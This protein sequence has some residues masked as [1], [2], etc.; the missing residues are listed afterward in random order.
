MK[1]KY[2]KPKSGNRLKYSRAKSTGDAH[3][4]FLVSQ[5]PQLLVL[6]F[7]NC[8]FFFFLKLSSGTLAACRRND[9]MIRATGRRYT[10]GFYIV[11]HPWLLNN[12]VVKVGYSTNV[13]Q[14]FETASYKT[15]FTPEWCF[16]RVLECESE[17]DAL[18]L[19]QAVLHCLGPYRVYRRELLRASAEKVGKAA[20]EIAQRLHINVIIHTNF[21]SNFS[22][23]KKK[24]DR[25]SGIHDEEEA[26]LEDSATELFDSDKGISSKSSEKDKEIPLKKTRTKYLD[27]PSPSQE[28]HDP[29]AQAITPFL[30]ILNSLSFDK[31]PEINRSTSVMQDSSSN[32]ALPD[33]EE[34]DLCGSWGEASLPYDFIDEKSYHLGDLRPY[35]KE[36]VQRLR[37]ELLRNGKAICQMACRCGKTPVAFQLI[38]EYFSLNYKS[39]SFV[40][41]K[42][43]GKK[44]II[45][46]LVPGLSLLRQT[47][48]KLFQYGLGQ[49]KVRFVLIG[50]HPDPVFLSPSSVTPMTTDVQY[51]KD[52]TLRD[53]NILVISTYHSSSLLKEV[54]ARSSLVVFDECHRICGSSEATLFNALLQTPSCGARLFMTATPTYDTPIKMNN[55][56]YFGSI[57]FRYYLREG[58]NSGY[59]NPFGVRIILGHSLDNMN[60]FLLEAMSHVDKLLVFCR[61]IDHAE[62]LFKRA[63]EEVGKSESSSGEVLPF[64]CFVAHSRMSCNSVSSA[65]QQFMSCKRGILFNVRLFQEGVEIPDLNGVFFACPRYSSRDIIQSICRPLSKVEG[66]PMSFVFLPAVLDSKSPDSSPINLENFSTLVP[67]ADALMDEDP[68]L[69]EY[70]IDPENKTYN[71]SVVGVRSLPLMSER[72]QQFILPS[73]RRG[74]RFSSRNSD[75]LRRVNRFPWKNVFAEL[76]RVVEECNRYPKTNDA[77]VVG[78]TSFS[79]NSFYQ[80][81]RKGYH[82]YERNQPTFLKVHQL[83]DLE[84][85]PFWKQYGVNGPYPWS[86]CMKTLKTFLH[87]Y[88]AC[89]PLDVHK[90]GYVGLDAT[91]LERLCGFLM[92]VNQCDA[93]CSVRLSPAKQAAMD[94]VCAEFNLVWR[95]ERDAKGVILPSSRLT[96]ITRSYNA[97][98]YMFENIDKFPSF[99]VYLQENFPGYPEKHMR[100]ERLETLQQGTIPPR[101]N[102]G[103]FKVN[104]SKTVAVKP[105]LSASRRI[106]PDWGWT[107]R[108][109]C[110]VCRLHI[111]VEEWEKH[112]VSSEHFQKLAAIR[113]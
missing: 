32:G 61:D 21:Q 7:L 6:I 108:V 79:L 56:K 99:R 18:I 25:I 113:K 14:R 42:R 70:M 13:E 67:F 2:F 35:Q 88:G 46:Y 78:Q 83:R 50:S 53:E 94:D 69:F 80:F 38:R 64:Q 29:L 9:C 41:K 15:C 5:L 57:A 23:S 110:R 109:M 111:L 91:P 27:D 100:M 86:E 44:S 33:E 22:F 75:R 45:I 63:K 28:M 107:P 20:E 77:W 8:L 96:F 112:L 89:P 93:K 26:I 43:E 48:Q 68:S 11:V 105:A 85:L 106:L 58:I 97:F 101:Y 76:R 55:E 103:T 82:L 59:V 10:I 24:R 30:P 37:T 16:Y 31:K 60:P 49:E 17:L 92:H 84:S 3:L 51:I 65:L 40:S 34:T 98:K 90:G 12:G 102:P 36:A 72:I 81:C 54:H 47:A 1:G 19:E 74:V 66:K 4:L 95:K 104:N 73:I 52:I 62:E 71:L 87:H 39:G